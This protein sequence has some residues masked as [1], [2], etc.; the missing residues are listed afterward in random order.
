MPGATKNTQ[1]QRN[2]KSNKQL[3]ETKAGPTFTESKEINPKKKSLAPSVKSD[4]ADSLSPDLAKDR[5]QVL[6]K[7][8]IKKL[9]AALDSSSWRDEL[10]KV[11]YETDIQ[12]GESERDDCS[13]FKGFL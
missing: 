7:D 4:R 3:E 2:Y 11:S 6:E 9:S 12:D 1:D 10:K 5:I 8:Y 13:P